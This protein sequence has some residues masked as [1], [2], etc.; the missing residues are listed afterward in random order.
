MTDKVVYL[1]ILVVALMGLFMFMRTRS[2]KSRNQLR[3]RRHNL[4]DRLRSDEPDPK[5][6]VND[7]QP[8]D[9]V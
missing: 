2:R 3:S 9:R 6:P 4:V 7:D 8:D 1:V 5:E